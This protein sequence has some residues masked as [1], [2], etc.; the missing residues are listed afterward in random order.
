MRWLL[1][2]LCLALPALAGELPRPVTDAHYRPIDPAEARLGWF[3]FY[4]PILSGNRNIACATCHHPRFATSDGV[5]LSLGEGGLGL[6]PERRPDPDN[7]PEQ[8][9]PRNAP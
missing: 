6:G 9:L 4:D 8:R 1:A 3:L 2:L 5:S 7:M